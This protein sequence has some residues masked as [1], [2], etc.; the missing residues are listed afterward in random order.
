[1]QYQ[2]FVI[3]HEVRTQ[4]TTVARPVPDES[5]V[6]AQTRRPVTVVAT[7]GTIAMAGA[8]ARPALDVASLVAAVPGLADVEGLRTRSILELP[9][10]HVSSADAL[11]IARAALEEAAAGRGVVITHGT[12]TIEET[13]VLCDVLHG[14]SEPIVLTGAIRPSGAAGADGPA[15]LLDAVAAAG[16]ADTADLGALVCFAGELH[17]ARAVRKVASVSPAAFGSPS[18]GPIG[19]VAEGRVR[20]AMHPV[21]P[22][23]LPLPAALDARVPIVPTFLGDDGAGLRAAVRD[24]ADAIV[25]VAFGAGHVAPEVLR[26]LREAAAQVPVA[27]TVWP[28]RGLLLRETY[29]FEGCEGDVRSSGAL[30]AGSLSARAA[31]MIVLAGVCGGAPA[32]ALR[33]ALDG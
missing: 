7:G 19:R 23:P 12:D 32:A 24:G 29:G 25:F 4:G 31:R 10:A 1:M 14:G 28:E 8:L 5:P 26:A 2:S 18:H 13:A 22:A 27:V 11:A 30:A 15:N 17:A 21:R 33:A 9:G 6:P 20:I 16:S 3:L